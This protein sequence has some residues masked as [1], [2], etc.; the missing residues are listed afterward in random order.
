MGLFDFLQGANVEEVVP[1]KRGGGRSKQWQ[2]NPGI[3]AIRLFRDGSVFPSA[4]AIEKFDLEYKDATITKEKLPLKDGQTEANQKYKN[5]YKYPDGSGNGFDVIDSRSWEQFKT[6]AEGGMLF[7]VPTAKTQGKVDLFGTCNYD[8]STGKPKVS[9]AEQG[10]A[11]F[12]KDVLLKAVSELYGT[13][14]AVDAKPAVEAAEGKPAKPAVEAVEGVDYVDL[15]IFETLG[16][17]NIT[18][19]YSKPILFIPKRIVRGEDAGKSDYVRREN[20]K[21]YGFA[22]AAMVL[23]DYQPDAPKEDN[24]EQAGE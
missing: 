15:A 23:T 14:W 21:V 13:V 18:E 4:A 20:A 12:G 11:T 6:S 5:V 9:V 24:E 10:A 8:D 22:P 1:S 7:I 16:S 3:I 19:K 2:P 17:L